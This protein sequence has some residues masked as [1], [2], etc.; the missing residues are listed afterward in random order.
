M[1][2]RK[3]NRHVACHED[4]KT[5]SFR[6]MPDVLTYFEHRWRPSASLLDGLARMLKQEL[7]HTRQMLRLAQ[8]QR[9]RRGK[10]VRV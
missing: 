6:Y 1:K 9:P 8:A 2:N 7:L 5:P 4:A 3:V 10:S